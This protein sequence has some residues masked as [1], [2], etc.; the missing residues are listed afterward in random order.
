MAIRFLSHGIENHLIV[1]TDQKT[2]IRFII[3]KETT[4]CCSCLGHNLLEVTKNYFHYKKKIKILFRN[5]FDWSCTEKLLHMKSWI[6]FYFKRNLPQRQTKTNIT[7]ISSTKPS[8]K[9]SKGK[10]NKKIR[11]SRKLKNCNCILIFGSKQ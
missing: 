5:F 9:D 10:I 2:K 11:G 4:I 8:T 6:A 1:H 3:S 7:L